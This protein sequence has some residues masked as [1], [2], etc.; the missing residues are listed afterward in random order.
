VDDALNLVELGEMGA[1][2]R[3]LPEH[4]TY[5]EDPAWLVGVVGDVTDGVHRRVSPQKRLLSLVPVESAAPSPASG[6]MAVLVHAG[7]QVEV[8][9]LDLDLLRLG[10]VEGV[11]HRPRGMRLGYEQSVHVPPG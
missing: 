10:Q 9:V 8:L 4:P 3:L 7:P 6:V 11:L 1:V 5:P 2:N